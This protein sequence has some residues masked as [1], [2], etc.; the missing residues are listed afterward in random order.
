M[1]K[2]KEVNDY[3]TEQLRRYK[4]G[5]AWI[6]ATDTL[7][8]GKFVWMDGSHVNYTNWGLWEGGGD[9]DDC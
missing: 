7:I 5:E 9:T 8:E 1:I 6:G 3:V 4:A 2:S